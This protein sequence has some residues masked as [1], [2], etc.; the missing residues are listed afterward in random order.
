MGRQIEERDKSALLKLIFGRQTS[1]EISSNHFLEFAKQFLAH[2]VIGL[3]LGASI[4]RIGGVFREYVLTQISFYENDD[5][6]KGEY[7]NK[8]LLYSDI[9][10]R[11]VLLNL[12]ILQ[13]LINVVVI[14]LLTR[15]LPPHIYERWQGTIP[16]LAFAALL[17]GIQSNMFKNIRAVIKE[18][19]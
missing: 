4:D 19:E 6:N 16:G 14:F 1:D 18:T 12:G 2:G 13:L 9:V 10:G 8:V 15:F 5:K 3:V 17:F 7:V 11:I